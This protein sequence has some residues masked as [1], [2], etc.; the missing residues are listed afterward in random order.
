LAETTPNIKMRKPL[1]NDSVDIAVI[2]ENMDK[3]DQALGDMA[4]VSTTAKDAA[5]AIS[6]LMGVIARDATLLTKG[7]VQLSSSFDSE[8]EAFAATPKAVKTAYHLAETAIANI[9][10]IQ[11]AVGSKAPI[12]N[13]VFTGAVTLSSDPTAILHAVT[14]R[15]VDS[16]VAS[17]KT[18]QP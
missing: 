4:S 16:Q 13:P 9:Q 12:N 11:A 15:Y 6:E 8:S 14:K 1:E 3:I 17:A 5:G 2:N 7:L 10:S 18:Y